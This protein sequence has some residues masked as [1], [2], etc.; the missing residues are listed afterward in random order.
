[1]SDLPRSSD[2]D[3]SLGGQAVDQGARA[4][5]QTDD[6][7][8]SEEDVVENLR[9]Q[10]QDLE[11][12]GAAERKARE[13]AERRASDAERA[14]QDAERR[15]NDATQ[16]ARQA[17]QQSERSVAESQL[18]AVKNALASQSTQLKSMSTAKAAALQEGNFDKAAE[19]DADMA[20]MG[21]EIAQLRAGQAELERRVKEPAPDAG[22][23]PQQQQSEYETR[24]NF[25]RGQPPKIQQWLRGPNGD[26]YFSDRAFQ[27]KV[28]S[29]ADYAAKVKN[30][31]VDSQDYIDFIETD[32]GLRQAADQ[33][34]TPT[35]TP[36]NGQGRVAD[37]GARMTTAPAGGST[38]GAIRANADGSTTVYLTPAEKEQARRD[39]ISESDWARHKRDLINENLIGPGARR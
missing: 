16:Q 19:L 6:V 3:P 35:P 14:R 21:G 11:G 32:L 25:I 37:N 10:L 33:T 22:R 26:R 2:P 34:P 28:A 1:M 20:I 9:R 23:Q 31:A 8:Q 5:S 18:D 29:A 27:Q 15:A 4:N 12:T 39:G 38:G 24:E 7:V 30:L 13:E 17:S 36:S